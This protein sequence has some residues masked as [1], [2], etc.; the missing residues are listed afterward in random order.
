MAVT[1]SKKPEPS[2]PA[3]AAKP[4]T[5]EKKAE[6]APKAVA[7]SFVVQ[8]GAFSSEARANVAAKSV[9]GHV[10]KAGKLWRVRMGP[11]ASDGEAKAA[12]DKAKAKGFRDATVLRDR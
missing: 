2:K 12:Q 3:P 5:P 9:G 1:S 10:D 6:P 11:F 8:V 7:G 4:A